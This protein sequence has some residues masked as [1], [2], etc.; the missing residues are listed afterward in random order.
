MV[1]IL[2]IFKKYRSVV[3][4]VASISIGYLINSLLSGISTTESV[5]KQYLAIELIIAIIIIISTFLAFL[6]LIDYFIEWKIIQNIKDENTKLPKD[7]RTLLFKKI[8]IFDNNSITTHE[9]TT[10]VE[11]TIK[12]DMK[13]QNYPEYRIE[14]ISKV[15]VPEFSKIKFTKDGKDFDKITEQSSRASLYDVIEKPSNEIISKKLRFCFP[16]D[17]AP[18]KEGSFSTEYKTKAFSAAIEGNCDY[19]AITSR[20]VINEII[21]EIR[22][23]GPIKDTYE[24]S[25]CIDRN[26]SEP[27]I[28]QIVD[29][30]MERMW[31]TENEGGKNN[32]IP[33]FHKDKITWNIKHVKVG[34]EYRLYFTLFKKNGTILTT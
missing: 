8:I 21:F 24:L 23:D 11:R 13:N 16:I 20:R 32:E 5:N 3:S 27:Y 19:T 34:Y 1:D 4:V 2:E 18:E 9:S 31:L 22:L 17:L 33:V 28:Y 6:W 12:N 25:K 15:D 14:Q 30:S 26:G 7:V 10:I 29:E